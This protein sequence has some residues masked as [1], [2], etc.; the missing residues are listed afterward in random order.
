[1]SESTPIAEDAGPRD[2]VSSPTGAYSA[3]S[4]R[5][6]LAI[7]MVLG[8]VA[9]AAGS[10]VIF[11]VREL[12]QVAPERLG[13]PPRPPQIEREVF[14]DAI[15][16]H[17]LGFGTLGLLIC[18]GLGF[19]LG[20]LGGSPGAGLRSLLVGSV[21]GLLCGA[22]GGAAAFLIY[23]ALVYVSLDGLFKAMLIHL[24]NWLL[25]AGGI[26]ITAALLRQQRAG[27]QKLFVSAFVAGLAAALLYP[28]LGLVVFPAA[29]S[30]RPV[31]FELGLRLLCFAL[32]GAVL[33]VA[34]SRWLHSPSAAQS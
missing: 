6:A 17:A 20:L 33:G 13:M 24:P 8:G 23:E 10:H 21:L 22:A 30:D 19:G 3:R 34:S 11:Q 25:L 29:S 18:G 7:L 5:W 14:L 16:N 28:I 9:G 26:A 27:V 31:P 15:A 12:F 4:V 2:V 1:M 32:G